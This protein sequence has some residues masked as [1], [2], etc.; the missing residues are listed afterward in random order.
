MILLGA[1]I[2]GR[3]FDS[4]GARWVGTI[5]GGL[6]GLRGQLVALLQSVGAG[7]TGALESA[8][9]SLYFT[10]EGRRGMLEEEAEK[11]KGGKEGS[12]EVEAPK[13]P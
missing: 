2:E 12:G 6:E 8:S 11:A 10:I 4:E 1:R 9:R 7:V 5:D 13:E 3:V